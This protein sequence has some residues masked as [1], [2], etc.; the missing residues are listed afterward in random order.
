[1]KKAIATGVLLIILLATSIFLARVS[2]G[3]EGKDRGST[4]RS[5]VEARL[6]RESGHGSSTRVELGRSSPA[7]RMNRSSGNVDGGREFERIQR[8]RIRD[9]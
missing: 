4:G 8:D 2:S 6:N 3:A 9:R 1:V 7:D 5:N